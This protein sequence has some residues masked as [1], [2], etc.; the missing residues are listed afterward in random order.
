MKWQ[1]TQENEE[2]QKS[3]VSSRGREGNVVSN[4]GDMSSKKRAKG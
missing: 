2:S 1:N 3:A 4:V